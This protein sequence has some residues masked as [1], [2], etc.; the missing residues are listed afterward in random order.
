MGTTCEGCHDCGTHTSPYLPKASSTRLIHQCDLDNDDD[1]DDNSSNKK[2]DE[3][4]SR[5]H[6]HLRANTEKDLNKDH[7]STSTKMKKSTFSLGCR[8]AQECTT[9]MSTTATVGDTNSNNINKLCLIR[10]GYTEGSTWTAIEVNDLVAFGHSGGTTQ[11]DKD[12]SIWDAVVAYSFGCQM[13]VKGLFKEQYADGILGLL[14][15]EHSIVKAMAAQKIIAT[16]SFSLCLHSAGGWM[17]LGG[18]QV[19]RHLEPMR[20]TPIVPAPHKHPWY[21]VSV[22]QVYMDDILITD[23]DTNPHILKALHG[24]RG[25]VLDSGTTDIYLPTIMEPVIATVWKD[26]TSGHVWKKHTQK[27]TYDAFLRLPL[28]HFI[29][30]GNVTITLEPRYYMD[31]DG[32]LDMPWDGTKSLSN[33]IRTEEDTGAVF[34]FNGMAGYDFYYKESHIGIARADCERGFVWQDDDNMTD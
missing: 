16:E 25:T 15:T 20:F 22:V 34:G 2:Q 11:L 24:G 18:A 27:Y 3:M 10:Q 28:F 31:H 8:M 33:L 32:T 9:T 19:D 26:R 1:E 29:L 5:H 7:T 17:A 30:Q 12:E 21:S 4:S 23:K 14:R 13:E 6:P